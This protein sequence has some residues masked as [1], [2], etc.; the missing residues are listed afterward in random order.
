M[1]FY[2]LFLLFLSIFC[3]DLHQRRSVWFTVVHQPDSQAE[4]WRTAG[5][6]HQ[7]DHPPSEQIPGLQV[8][9]ELF[10]HIQI[11]YMS[12]NLYLS[13]GNQRVMSEREKTT[14]SKRNRVRERWMEEKGESEKRCQKVR[15]KRD[16]WSFNWTWHLWLWSNVLS[17]FISHKKPMW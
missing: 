15:S 16:N 13:F 7:F 8:H 3:P 17:L 14:R 10:N 4:V 6:S 12:Q 11:L 1:S 5:K 9:R 2:G